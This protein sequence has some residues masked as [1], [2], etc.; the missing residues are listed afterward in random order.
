[1]TILDFFAIVVG[2]LD[3]LMSIIKKI[4]IVCNHQLSLISCIGLNKH[5]DFSLTYFSDYSQNFVYI[6]Y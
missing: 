4:K 2:V 3:L 1:M 5:F 6:W